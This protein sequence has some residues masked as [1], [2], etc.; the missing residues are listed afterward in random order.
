[1]ITILKSTAI[2]ESS[3]INISDDP[4]FELVRELK[5][6]NLKAFSKL[7]NSYAPALLWI[8]EKIV[9]STPCS[10][11]VLQ[12]T[13]IK[14]SRSI[15]TYDPHKGKLFTWMARTAR[16]TAIDLLRNRDHL[17]AN[18][19]EDLEILVEKQDIN[20][21]FVYNPETIGIRQLIT[22]LPV[23][24]REVME[25]FYFQGYTHSQVSK[26]LNIPIGTVKTR[27]RSSIIILREF[28]K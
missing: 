16:N 5:A 13:F 24:Q 6:G 14:I 2:N 17:N 23:P 25:L 9:K 4:T 20:F 15:L 21:S 1:M 18:K 27:L 10:E 3:G 28:F 19:N 11:D 26:E 12:E 7:Y 8:I 22:I